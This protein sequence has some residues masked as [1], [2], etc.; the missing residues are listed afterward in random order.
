M[1]SVSVWLVKTK[2]LAS[3]SARSSSWFSMMPLC[4]NAMRPC[5]SAAARAPGEKCG[6]ALATAGA[7]CVA[8]RVCAMPVPAARF[9]A[10][11]C[12]S[13][14]ATREVLRARLS[15]PS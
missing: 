9:S 3:S 1:T 12:A 8:Q 10:A 6:C 7:P 11:T 15:C 4:T 14:S 13:S 2:P 5:A